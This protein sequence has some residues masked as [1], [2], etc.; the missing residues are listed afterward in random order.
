[1][2]ILKRRVFAARLFAE[3]LR[4]PNFVR[5]DYSL[6]F[7]CRSYGIEGELLT[8]AECGEKWGAGDPGLLATEDLAGGVWLP[9]DGSASPTDL[10]AALLKGARKGGA[11]TR[12]RVRV[13]EVLT[14]SNAL[15]GER[16]ATGVKTACGAQVSCD[17]LV[18]CGG[19]WSRQFGAKAGVTVPLHSAEHFYVIT[20]EVEGITGD[21]PVL[22]D[23][24]GLIY[25][26]EWGGGHAEVPDLFC[27]MCFAFVSCPHCCISLYWETFPSTALT[28]A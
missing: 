23:P 14:R 1:L 20:N 10:T 28:I 2:S 17:V 22:R 6:L 9:M 27:I 26:R 18:L 12:E 13:D 19:Q 3:R 7:F 16:E 4:S 5:I 24:D 25:A 15:T 21:T 11:Q 8:P